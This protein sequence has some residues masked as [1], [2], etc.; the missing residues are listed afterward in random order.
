[1]T[2]QPK[3]PEASLPE[4]R[5]DFRELFNRHYV[6]LCMY[7]F[8]KV[9]N[10]EAA[11]EI[12]QELFVHLWEKR[13]EITIHTS[14]SAYLYR[15]VLHASLNYIK[16]NSIVERTHLKISESDTEQPVQPDALA[17]EGELYETL[18]SVLEKLPGRTRLIFEKIRFE[19]KKYREVADELK[20]SVKTVEAHMSE[21]LRILRIALKNFLT[22]LLLLALL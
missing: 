15:S 22:V 14:L 18:L 10:Q 13:N 2:S 19:G 11:R 4:N 3:S 21:A 12:V 8:S 9:R 6:P 16:H 5:N 1:M 7:A 20:I 17:E